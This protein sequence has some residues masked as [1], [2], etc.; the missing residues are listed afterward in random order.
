[1]WLFVHFGLI[2]IAIDEKGF[3]R[4]SNVGKIS[5]EIISG[6]SELLLIQLSVGILRQ[7]IILLYI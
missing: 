5:P 4:F 6:Q 2:I 3:L 7:S 1:M